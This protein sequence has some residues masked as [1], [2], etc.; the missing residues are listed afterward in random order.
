MIDDFWLIKFTCNNDNLNSAEFK[1]WI[2]FLEVCVGD[3]QLT[4][5]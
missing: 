2:C 3:Q 5:D 1:K 4:N